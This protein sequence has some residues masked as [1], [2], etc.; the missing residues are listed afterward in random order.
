MPQHK[1]D[2]HPANKPGAGA[3]HH[4]RDAADGAR[5]RDLA[6]DSLLDL[7]AVWEDQYLCGNDL[8]AESL[9]VNDPALLE[10]LKRRID[11]QRRLLAFLGISPGWAASPEEIAYLHND[12]MGNASAKEHPA[13]ATAA[14]SPQTVPTNIGRYRVT[15]VLGQGGFGR[16][17][18]AHDPD[19][20]RDVAIKVPIPSGAAQFLDVEAYLS[21]ARILARLVHP[22]IVPVHDVGRTEDGRFY[23]VSKY[24]E[25]GD[26]SARL[27]SNRPTHV[28]SA[29]LVAVLCDALHYT[30]T[31]DLYHRDIKPANILLDAAGTPSLADFGLALR[32]ESV[33]LGARHVGTAAYMS[34]E[35]ARGEGHL[36]DGRSD[37]FGLGVVFYELLTSR[38]PFRGNTRAEV[39]D[40]ITGVEPRPPRQIDDSIPRELERICLKSLSKRATE[41]YSTARDLAD[42]LRHFID[43]A[44]AASKQ[45]S[46]EALA[47][48]PQS[49]AQSGT[50]ATNAALPVERSSIVVPKGL[51]AFDE[52]DADFFLELLP[53]P[54]DRD[55]L[56]ES[57]RFWKTRV[58]ECDPERSFRVGLI[59]G[60]SGCGKSSLV[61]AGLLPRLARHVQPVYLEAGPAEFEHR[62]LK[63]LQRRCP[64][65]PTDLD[66][67]RAVAAL[68]QRRIIPPGHKIVIVLDQFEQWLHAGQNSVDAPLVQ[69]LRQ[70]D[71]EHVQAVVLVRDDFWLAASRFLKNL[72]VRLLEG[73]NAALVD[74]FDPRHA[75]K[76]LAMLGRAFGALSNSHGLT[77]DEG[78]FLDEAIAGLARDGKIVPVRLALF[79]EMLKGKPWTMATLRAIGGTEGVGVTFLDE[80]FSA[81]TAPAQHRRH[82]EAARAILK[83]LI[84]ATEADIKGQVRT[85]KDLLDA[86]GYAERPEDF[87]DLIRIL[88]SELRLITPTHSSDQTDVGRPDGQAL[89]SC[90]LLAHDYMVRS[91][92][93]WLSRKQRE[94]R[95]GRAELC[96]AERT[97]LWTGRSENRLL[98][99]LNE[100]LQI[101]FGTRWKNWSLAE[102]AMMAAADRF[103]ALRIA[104]SAFV[105]LALVTLLFAAAA[106]ASAWRRRNEVSA[107]V[108]QLF[109]AEWSSLPNLL[110]S[111]DTER[112]LWSDELTRI[113]ADRSRP[114]GERQRMRLLLAHH[115]EAR[116]FELIDDISAANPAQLTVIIGRLVPWKTSVLP[117]IWSRLTTPDLAPDARMRLAAAAARLDPSNQ[118]WGSVAAAISSAL[119][120]E[121]D[122]LLLSAW[123]EFLRPVEVSIVE[124]LAAM[125]LNTQIGIEQRQV[126]AS[127][128][129][130]FGN[131]RPDLLEKVLLECDS[132]REFVVLWRKLAA[133]GESFA[134]RMRA[135]LGHG[136]TASGTNSD[137]P[138][139]ANAA[140]ALALLGD[141]S[142]VR[143]CLG[144]N[145]DTS[146]RTRLIHRMRDY[147]INALGLAAGLTPAHA[148]SVRQAILL[149]LRDYRPESI[150]S[151]ERSAILAYCQ[152]MFLTDPDAGVHAG[153]EVLLQAWGHGGLAGATES[154]PGWNARGQLVHDR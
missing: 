120:E 111:L 85:R 138:R 109:V 95:A 51:R 137:W 116:A 78:T 38:R 47:T 14:S 90:Y 56:P 45:G 98:P 93:Q 24:M 133:S 105:V 71:G 94:S 99:S 70:C 89:G 4:D 20:D 25:G 63:A 10:A 29:A 113:F 44:G 41:R 147:G 1:A 53:G 82:Q 37:I 87:D 150:P 143:P 84:P 26:L 139:R 80:T 57:L 76:V 12:E 7:M 141:W 21:E 119:L 106:A 136:S 124:P 125:C 79:A 40:K 117:L 118:E 74:L 129:A 101:R 65:L 72:D 66:L 16:I 132:S 49:P 58:E 134:A 114:P 126:A 67:P 149:A 61:R 108:A 123:I 23:V 102:R 96:L 135:V 33:G 121:A 148:A 83:S 48:T 13:V 50:P 36:V 151:T 75:R 35:Q 39:L 130:E 146:L 81:P 15:R 19:L 127:A 3:E 152:R 69:A 154:D 104:T 97:A 34:P 140:L 59:Y 11:E 103:H 115:N 27:L 2:P 153:C 145:A 62:L 64:E 30:H 88:D 100:W 6:S 9:G 60:P 54:R 68:R 92:R 86:S 144:D 17:Y 32:D 18:L 31:Q 43:S 73:S 112:S 5:D 128:L 77:R 52:H 46:M 28:E 107:L 142:E 55:G 8:P 42:D 131:D 91:L 122:P 22:N 110:R